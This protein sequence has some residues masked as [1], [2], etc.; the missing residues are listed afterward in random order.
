MSR[1]RHEH[2]L[3]AGWALVLVGC[4]GCAPAPQ[5]APGTV[6]AVPLATDE[7]PLP[8]RIGAL[9]LLGAYELRTADPNFGGISG[10]RLDDGR[11]L[12]LSDRSWL[13]E[14]RWPAHR[15]GAAFALPLLRQQALVDG[16]GRPLDAEALAVTPTG[17]MLVADEAEGRL[18]RYAPGGGAPKT[19]PRRLPALFAAQRPTNEGAEALAPLPDGSFLVIAE[20]GWL[21]DGL[22]ATVRL[23]EGGSQALRYRAKAGF[24][25]TDAEVAGDRLLVLERRLSLLGGWQARIVA[26]PLAELPTQPDG[27]IA[28]HELAIISG[29]VLG[30]NY[31]AITAWPDGAGGYRLLLVSDDNFSGLQRTQLLELGW[32]P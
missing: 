8:A 5:A 28:G 6:R 26:A 21:D 25:P 11:L 22:H 15:D 30:E 29:P 13:F 3:R 32:R 7:A 14:L 16:H 18:F 9:D 24:L 31:E 17:D 20:G 12:L 27:V 10:A 19:K 2:H 23:A 1:L 4:L